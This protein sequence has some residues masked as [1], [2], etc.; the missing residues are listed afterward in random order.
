MESSHS[1]DA[2]ESR[3]LTWGDLGKAWKANDDA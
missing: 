2:G 1:N 3:L